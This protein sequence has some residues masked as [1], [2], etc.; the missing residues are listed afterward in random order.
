MDLTIF[1]K[2]CKG[3]KQK[4]LEIVKQWYQL[5]SSRDTDDQRILE[6]DQPKSTSGHTQP[7]VVALNVNFL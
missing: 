7:T 4:R 1:E 6:S 2:K 5:I 3:N